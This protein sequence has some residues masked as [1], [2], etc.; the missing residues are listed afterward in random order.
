MDMRREAIRKARGYHKWAKEV[1]E[2]LNGKPIQY[3]THDGRWVDTSYPTF[4]EDD[5]YRIKPEPKI[6]PFDFT[7]AEK[8]IGKVVKHKIASDVFI[9]GRVITRG[10]L[11]VGWSIDFSDLLSDYVFLDGSPC[12]KETI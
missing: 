4:E 1:E 8:L 11:A 7:D 2:F 12:G 9:I 10:V 6:I 3:R 5:T